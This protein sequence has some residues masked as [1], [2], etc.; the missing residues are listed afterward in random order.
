M[1]AFRLS[2]FVVLF[3]LFGVIGFPL[4]YVTAILIGIARI[5]LDSY[6]EMR[7][8]R[9]SL[10]YIAFLAMLVSLI[11]GEYLAG[12]V[13]AFMFTSGK[14]LEKFAESR[15]EATLKSLGDTIPKRALV[16]RSD[17]FI[18]APL[19][20]VKNGERILIA[21]GE[22]IPLHGT[23]ASP[24]GIFDLKNLTG[25]MEPARFSAGTLIKSGTINSGD[26]VE[27]IVVGDFSSST[28]HRIV[29]LVD[30]AKAHPAPL[31][32]ISERANI[33]FTILT[34]LFAGAAYAFSGGDIVRL[35]A[36]LVIATPCPLIIAAPVAF[37]GGM[38][39]LARA[40]IILRKP[41][42]RRYPA[43]FYSLF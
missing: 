25:E 4:C 7:A 1:K 33:Y 19:Q 28:Y 23:L 5:A 21:R 38:S 17:R 40:S 30:E 2:L 42:A 8:G 3:L 31:V 22:L 29:G 11:S 43:I 26:A 15:A 34:L 12:A 27:I 13:V 35:L 6:Q 37:I 24:N 9:W 36:V 18:E 39:R 14:A 41:A 32:R 10:D 16:H 20:S